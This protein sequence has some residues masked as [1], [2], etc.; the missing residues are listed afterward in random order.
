VIVFFEP[1]S[2]ESNLLEFYGKFCNNSVLFFILFFQHKNIL[3]FALSRVFSGLSIS[4]ELFFSGVDGFILL[5]KRRSRKI[6]VLLFNI[7]SRLQEACHFVTIKNFLFLFGIFFV[8]FF[9]IFLLLCINL[10]ILLIHLLLDGYIT[11][12]LFVRRL[13]FAILL[14]E[15]I[16]PP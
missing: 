11:H 13:Y 3:F 1:V 16:R 7:F 2:L 4:L 8:I 6:L 5:M 14:K 9:A 10:I 12:I 15:I